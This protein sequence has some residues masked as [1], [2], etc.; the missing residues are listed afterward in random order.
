MPQL[1]D[2][3]AEFSAAAKL[4]EPGEL[5]KNDSFLLFD[6]V[7][8]LEI[9]DP[10]MDTGCM[11][12]DDGQIETFDPTVDLGGAQLLW[13]TDR[14]LSLE[15]AWMEGNPLSQTLLTSCHIDCLLSPSNRPPYKFA[16]SETTLVMALR[17]YCIGVVKCCEVVIDTI[18][19]QVYYEEEDFVTHTYGR[20]LLPKVDP[21][22]ADYL[23]DEALVSLQKAELGQELGQALTQR[24]QFRKNYLQALVSLG[25]E[26]QWT[27]IQALLTS[28]NTTHTLGQEIPTAFSIFLQKK[29]STNAPPRP[30]LTLTWPD[31][32]SKW[33]SL[34]NEQIQT[35]RLLTNL[36]PLALQT[37][38]WTF[39]YQ[40]PPPS[41]FS[42]AHFQT[43]IFNNTDS[44]QLLLSELRTLV[45][46]FSP[47]LNP[48]NFTLEAPQHPYYRTSCLLETLLLKSTEEY[49]NIYRMTLQNRCRMRRTFS[50]AIPI[51]SSLETLARSLDNQLTSILPHS[52]PTPFSSWAKFHKLCLMHS[53]LLLGVE[54]DLHLPDELAGVYYSSAVVSHNLCTLLEKLNPS[55][56]GMLRKA[57]LERLLA[58]ALWR[59]TSCLKL[60]GYIVPPKRAYADPQR[61][62]EARLK[63]FLG[64][65]RDRLPSCK[66]LSEAERRHVSLTETGRSVGLDVSEAK[67]VLKLWRREGDPREGRLLEATCVAIGILGVRMAQLGDG[68]GKEGKVEMKKWH[69]FWAVPVIK[70]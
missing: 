23:L 30:A 39:A 11:A 34:L 44:T 17:A 49:S 43:L 65:E 32:H 27:Y 59:A 5:V 31:T 63:P 60:N 8:A 37:S 6:A 3:T 42:R 48:N 15:I 67:D 69:P 45:L 57:K 7:S 41:P 4:L 16:E 61:L 46:P 18:Q 20:E 12:D 53:T 52:P 68:G 40:D 36:D 29:L 70:L 51:W 21:D 56:R 54:T 50:Q 1:R 9:M 28:I 64:V 62:Y 35:K 19:S 38:C 33:T 25:T 22:G 14:M 24:L 26:S 47:I 13:I 66:E 2:L 58:L 55:E 10:K